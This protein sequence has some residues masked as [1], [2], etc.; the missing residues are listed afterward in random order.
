M[1]AQHAR[2]TRL[3]TS[4]KRLVPGRGGRRAPRPSTASTPRRSRGTRT[5]ARTAPGGSSRPGRSGKATAQAVWELDK[6]RQGSP[7][8][9]TW[10]S[11]CA[12]S[13]PRTMLGQEPPARTARCPAAA[14]P[15]GRPRHAPRPARHGGA[16]AD[17]PVERPAGA[18]PARGSRRR[19][20]GPATRS[21]PAATRCSPRSTGRWA[22]SPAAGSTPAPA[23]VAQARRTGRRG[24]A[25]R[26]IGRSPFDD[27]TRPAQ[28]DPG[29]AVAGR[30]AP[31]A[32]H[33]VGRR[34]RPTGRRRTSRASACRAGTTCSS[35]AAPSPGPARETSSIACLAAGDQVGVHGVHQPRAD[36]PLGQPAVP[37]HHELRA[38][39]PPSPTASRSWTGRW[40]TASTSSTPPTSTA[41]SSAKASP[42]RS[43]AAG[44]PRAAAG[45][46]RSS[47]PPRSTARWASGPTTRACPRATSSRACE[48][49]LRRLQTDYIDLYQMHHIDRTTPWEEIW[50]AMELLVAQGKVL[51]VGSSQLRRLAH[52][53]GAGVGGAAA[54][55]RP[56]L[57][58]VHLQP[59]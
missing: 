40:S 54:L 36:R 27:D 14:R 59:A 51:Y 34:R 32:Q 28:G 46:R 15:A 41:G 35:A 11:T 29:G 38:R 26:L 30:A 21:G 55:P 43:S 20:P 37:G 58:A 44:S 33:A 3:K 16:R 6:A 8:T 12:P 18:A 10:R 5:G 24:A 25:R 13:A 17:P 9:T 22:R 49:S 7:R 53:A 45:A 31:A 56:G 39:R 4:D 52:R 19:G 47:S 50:Q 1:L 57:R 42:S 2:R 23:P 48:D